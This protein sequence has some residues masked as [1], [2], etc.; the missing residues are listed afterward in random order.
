MSRERLASGEHLVVLVSVR[1]GSTFVCTSIACAAF[2]RHPSRHLT[3]TMLTSSEAQFAKALQQDHPPM[4]PDPEP[5]QPRASP[6]GSPREFSPP[7]S[8]MSERRQ[9]LNPP[10]SLLVQDDGKLAK[11]HVQELRLSFDRWSKSSSPA[12]H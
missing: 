10:S 7:R 2:R 1:D 6:K 9:P 3:M 12:L 5:G 4:L 11:H 8:T